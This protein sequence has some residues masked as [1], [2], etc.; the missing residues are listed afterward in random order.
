MLLCIVGSQS[1]CCYRIE[2][3]CLAVAASELLL[4]VEANR[5]TNVMTKSFTAMFPHVERYYWTMVNQPN[6]KKP[7]KKPKKK[8]KKEPAKPTTEDIEEE[9]EAP[10][11]KA[12]NP[13]DLLPP[14]KM[15][16]DE[17]KRLYSNTKTNFREVAIKGINSIMSLMLLVGI[18][19][20]TFIL[21]LSLLFFFFFFCLLAYEMLRACGWF[22]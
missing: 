4:D 15:I 5:F 13:L 8:A 12:K 22:C 14:C 9:E 11:P 17:W 18:Y 2:V 1:S 16:L 20:N 6:F 3:Y 7:N 21:D 19:S 10:K